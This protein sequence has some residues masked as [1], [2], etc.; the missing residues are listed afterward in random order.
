M[1]AIMGGL[2]SPGLFHHERA[3]LL[4]RGAASRRAA[5]GH[6]RPAHAA[7]KRGLPLSQAKEAF[8]E[9][10]RGDLHRAT[11]DLADKASVVDGV[12][13]LCADQKKW[14]GHTGFAALLSGLQDAEIWSSFKLPKRETRLAV[15]QPGK[16]TGPINKHPIPPSHDRGDEVALDAGDDEGN[17]VAEDRDILRILDAADSQTRSLLIN[18]SNSST[19]GSH[20]LT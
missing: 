19:I 8:F 10:L 9:G 7:E 11:R 6:H 2:R 14:L 12:G 15:D 13:H 5:R 16:K 17:Q 18:L 20:L 4:L 3:H 1:P